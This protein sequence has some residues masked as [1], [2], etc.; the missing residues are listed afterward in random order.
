[1][2]GICYVKSL[3]DRG[4]KTILE[5]R[6]KEQR[7]R[8]TEGFGFIGIE[9]NREM[10]IVHSTTEVGALTELRK[11]NAT[12]V[13]FHHR[14]PTSTDN[15]INACHPFESVA[16][17]G[18]RFYLVH[19]GIVWNED[20]LK[21]RHKRFGI[22]YG[23]LQDDGRFNDSES[24]AH[25]FM[26]YITKRK[27]TFDGQGSIAIMVIETDK[28]RKATKL[29]YARN[30]GSPLVALKTRN[31]LQIA[32]EGEGSI[33]PCGKLYTLDYETMKT[34]SKDFVMET[35]TAPQIEYINMGMYN[36]EERYSNPYYDRYNHNSDDGIWKETKL[37]YARDDSG[38][39][40]ET[41]VPIDDDVKVLSLAES[42]CSDGYYDDDEEYEDDGYSLVHMGKQKPKYT[43]HALAKP[44]VLDLDTI[45][46]SFSEDYD[47]ERGLDDGEEQLF[48]MTDYK[49]I[50]E[51]VVELN[52][53]LKYLDGV[54]SLALPHED[55]S[56]LDKEV[57]DKSKDF[58]YWLGVAT[59]MYE[60]SVDYY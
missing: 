27:K 12:E 40:V 52:E 46:A 42:M 20:D 32:S 8:G 33:V 54:K 4:V 6:Y 17:D 10:T 41:Y 22:E 43:Y 7:N 51:L 11:S 2:C 34:T 59:K 35:Y 5:Q 37:L 16:K 26:L 21:K 50:T 56:D 29:H 55:T 28:D 18:R 36:H 23:S 48:T 58:V 47:F 38:E 44:P 45:Y 60:L 13:L 15:V 30:S 9:P 57:V 1:M 53:G 3:R 24:L 14:Y 19:N 39:L 25:E 31:T 49:W